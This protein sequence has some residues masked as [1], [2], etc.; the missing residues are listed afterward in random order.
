MGSKLSENFRVFANLGFYGQTIV[1]ITFFPKIAERLA[2]SSTGIGFLFD[3]SLI[4]R[5]LRVAILIHF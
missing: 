1:K 3:A 2:G 4:A 5:N